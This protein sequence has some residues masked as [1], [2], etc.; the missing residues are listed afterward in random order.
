MS[1]NKKGTAGDLFL[2]IL[3]GLLAIYIYGL[4]MKG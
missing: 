3:F 4:A 2:L 1:K